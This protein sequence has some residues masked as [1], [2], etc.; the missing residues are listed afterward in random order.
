MQAKIERLYGFLILL[1]ETQRENPGFLNRDI[2]N[3]VNALLTEIKLGKTPTL[4][5][6]ALLCESIKAFKR[7]DPFLD[8]AYLILKLYRERAA[9]QSDEKAL[10]PAEQSEIPPNL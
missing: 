9:A 10:S 2:E 1:K 7:K 4:S 8:F 6:V 3:S 5:K